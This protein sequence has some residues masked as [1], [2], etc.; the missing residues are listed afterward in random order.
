[1]DEP[2]LVDTI[3][4]FVGSETWAEGQVFL[5]LHPE[6]LSDEAIAILDALADAQEN[7]RLRK[8]FEYH[9]KLLL[10]CRQIGIGP[11]FTKLIA[12]AMPE[13]P[14]E[15]WHAIQQA[16]TAE[17]RH[18]YSGNLQ[19]LDQALGAWEKILNH[20]NYHL[21][22]LE[23]QLSA[24]NNAGGVYH[25]RYA[26]SGQGIDLERCVE[27]FRT[28]VRLTPNE[29]PFLAERFNNLSVSLL[30]HADQSGVASDLEEALYAAQKAVDLTPADS[31]DFIGYLSTLGTVLY[32]YYVF[33][34][35]PE[36]LHHA[37]AFQEQVIEEAGSASSDLPMYQFNLGLSLLVKYQSS[38]ETSELE[39]AIRCLQDAAERVDPSSASYPVYLNQFGNALKLYSTLSGSTEE[40]EK[41]IQILKE[42]VIRLPPGSPDTAMIQ[43]NLGSALGEY[44]AQTG[45]LEYLQE[46]L[47]A[48][49]IAVR[50]THPDSPGM[51]ARLN[52][53]GSLLLE[54][55]EATGNQKALD[56]A[57]RSLR[58][59]VRSTWEN[60]PDLPARINNLGN[61]LNLL[62]TRTGDSA[63]LNESI[64]LLKPVAASAVVN[65]QERPGIL[66]SL[67]NSL[68]D[69][70]LQTGDLEDLESAVKAH[71]EAVTLTPLTAI[72][73]PRR[74]NGLGYALRSRYMVTGKLQDLEKAIAAYREAALANP[75][76]ISIERVK[77]LNNLGNGLGDLYSRTGN[78]ADLD[79]AVRVYQDALVLCPPNSPDRSILLN[80]LGSALRDRC[81]H[82]ENMQDLEMAISS[83]RAAIQATP[84]DSPDLAIRLNNLGIALNNLFTMNR[85]VADLDEAI[86]QIR[87]AIQI[88]PPN[89]P[90]LAMFFN[91]LG[92]ALIDRNTVTGN[93]KD[94]KEAV[95]FY[96]KAIRSTQSASPSLPKYYNNLGIALT[97]LHTDTGDLHFLEDAVSA[98]HQSWQKLDL[99]FAQS[100]VSFKL[101]QQG[102][103]SGLFSL[104]VEAAIRLARLS[105]SVPLS[106]DAS[107]QALLF[108]EG[109][110]SRIL[111]EVIGRRKAPAPDVI[112]ED[113]LKEERQIVN[114]IEALDLQESYHQFNSQVSPEPTK[115]E[116]YKELS[117][118]LDKLHSLWK[119]M[120]SL[121]PLAA[122]YVS[123]RRGDR[124]DWHSIR[125][126]TDRL[127][128][129]TALLSQ[130]IG[131]NSTFI[132]IVRSGMEAPQV[133]DAPISAWDWEDTLNRV[134]RDIHE[135]SSSSRRGETW[136][137]RLHPLWSEVVKA[138]DGATSLVISPHR[139]G[140][141]IPWPAIPVGGTRLGH[142]FKLVTVPALNMLNNL[143]ARPQISTRKAFV[144]A[145]PTGDLP[146]AENEARQIARLFG[147]EPVIGHRVTRDM[148]EKELPTVDVAHVAAH[149]FFDA[150]E[151]LNSGINLA[152]GIFTAEQ[153]MRLQLDLDLLAISACQSGVSQS[154]AGEELAGLSQAFLFAGSRSLLVSLW[155]VDDTVTSFFMNSF[156]EGYVREGLDKASSL[157]YAMKETAHRWPHP[158]FWAA[159]TLIGMV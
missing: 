67:G 40:L 126:I 42:S 127:G 81:A 58:D 57:V 98:F 117:E 33:S 2:S 87:K 154:L 113:W 90:N 50:L 64:E 131:T 59:S 104:S 25:K 34:G 6:L 115:V 68:H 88:S 137:S 32:Q 93:A 39:K 110:K 150:N 17:A 107:I 24:Y 54:E 65:S 10:D 75:A 82:T 23:F 109:S 97:E 70:F 55:Y 99:A 4:V 139:Q 85:F 152:D 118:L 49:R 142:Q 72:T 77:Y 103:F 92:N 129:E 74:M 19:N 123:I 73:Y 124:P 31:P 5:E 141:S 100:P 114:Q 7:E 95:D 155:P 36:Y 148:V 20:P 53:L 156:Y 120:E 116:K 140:H 132:F 51:A 94:V 63:L 102:L 122:N 28:S 80:N 91:N 14:Q 29:S 48:H 86:Q 21:S 83:Y 136:Y 18:D 121:G 138:L 69:R 60:S 66:N 133:I 119:Q 128:P 157:Q 151:P 105:R 145:D 56:E 11:A 27:L 135:Y 144:A 153:A 37:T 26:L 79:E 147:T 89:T 149:A 134:K 108:A 30:D 76:T 62:F 71:R 3:L 130:F 112:P 106:R 111:G 1:M 46:A 45:N 22:P 84:P 38:G 43:D 15:Y 41:A 47:N 8:T 158:Y 13:A 44:F 159:F 96:R 9:R 16:E 35:N 61:G 143:L 78:L 125:S 146:G 12:E 52:N 101:G